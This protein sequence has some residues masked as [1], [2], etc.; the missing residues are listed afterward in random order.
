MQFYPQYPTGGY[1]TGFQSAA[2]YSGPGGGPGPA[3]NLADFVEP[4]NLEPGWTL[5]ISVD[6]DPDDTAT[7]NATPANQHSG[8]ADPY[9]VDT[10]TLILRVGPASEPTQT[11]VLAGVAATAAQ[12]AAQIGAA[13]TGV[14]SYDAGGGE[15]DIDTDQQGTGARLEIVGGTALAALG[16]VANVATGTGNVADIDAV[17]AGEV[18]SIVLAAVTPDAT[19]TVQGGRPEICSVSTGPTASLEVTGGLAQAPIGFRAGEING[20]ASTG[21]IAIRWGK[22]RGILVIPPA[23]PEPPG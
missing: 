11:V 19:T 12:V 7:F 23:E 15:V 20:F 14:Q 9:N 3:C 4:Y 13:I 18:A 22:S 8:N 1:L 16:Y 10:L 2:N 6:G 5:T 21:L 17:T